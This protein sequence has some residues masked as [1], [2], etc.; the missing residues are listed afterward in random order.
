MRTIPRFGIGAP[1]DLKTTVREAIPQGG[2]ADPFIYGTT[3]VWHDSVNNVMRHLDGTDP[4]TE[5]EGAVLVKASDTGE[6]G[7]ADPF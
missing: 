4:T 2:W 5:T 1:E 6:A 7:Q 3:R